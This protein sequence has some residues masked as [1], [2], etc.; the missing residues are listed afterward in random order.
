MFFNNNLLTFLPLSWSSVESC[1]SV[2]TDSNEVYTATEETQAETACAYILNDD[3]F[4]QC[5][6]TVVPTTYYQ[7]CISN[8]K[9]C[10]GDKNM[11]QCEALEMYDSACYQNG[12]YLNW[13]SDSLCPADCDEGEEFQS[14]LRSCYRTCE[15]KGSENIVCDST[16]TR[17]CNCP[18]GYL[19]NAT[20]GGVC[21]EESACP[22][23]YEDSKYNISDIYPSIANRKSPPLYCL[24][25]P[26]Y[27]YPP[28]PHSSNPMRST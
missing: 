4:A 11:C 16:C 5:H 23:T 28:L 25:Q 2:V 17:G 20:T 26:D 8:M 24:Q 21:I 22:C 7:I 9:N 3:V 13:H 19:L 15:D 12:V 6:G 27:C 14:C 10:I 1:E 18:S